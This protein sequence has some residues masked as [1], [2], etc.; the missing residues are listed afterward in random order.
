MSSDICPKCG[1]E[2]IHKNRYQ[3]VTSNG[4][5]GVVWHDKKVTYSQLFGNHTIWSD[6]CYLTKE[7][8]E[9]IV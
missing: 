3:C 9:K 2:I 8:W 7:E 6:G 4:I 1:R 5:T